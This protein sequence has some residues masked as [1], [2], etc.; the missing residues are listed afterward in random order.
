MRR[1]RPL[2]VVVTAIAVLVPLL[3]VAAVVTALREGQHADFG[4]KPRMD[5]PRAFAKDGPR[6]L[7]DE[8]HHNASDASWTG[9]YLPFA[10]LLRADGYRVRRCRDR[11]TPA[12]LRKTDILVIAN[13]TGGGKPQVLGINLP[14]SVE[15]RRGAP[16]FTAD[17]VAAVRSWVEDGGSLLLIADHAPMGAAAE[18]MAAAFGVRMNKGF[19]E[20]S[21]EVSDPLV[22]SRE[23]GR[24]GDHPI[25]RGASEA[26]SARRVMTFTGQSLDGPE[27][28]AILLA[29][30]PGAVEYVPAKPEFLEQPAGSAQGLALEYGRGRLV[31]LGEAAMLTAQVYKKERFGMNGP[32]NDNERFARNLLLWLSRAL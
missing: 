3:L 16:A 8:A 11:F 27:G 12:R 26:T 6:V 2:R 7:I 32:E 20:V 9:R 17:E 4:W 18:A 31:V 29:L 15:D 25:V 10:R 14:S 13:A 24:L 5:G 22:F 28:A 1:K 19:V 21:G 30:P 23:N